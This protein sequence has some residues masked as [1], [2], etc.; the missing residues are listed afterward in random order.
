MAA[1]ADLPPDELLD[2]DAA[3]T[4]FE[5]E[6]PEKAALVRLRFLAGLPEAEAAACLGLSRAT[7]SR[8]WAYARAWL[9]DRLGGADN[10]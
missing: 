6:E 9:L 5:A 10:P 7:A 3:L 4:A 8:H 2:L 1:A